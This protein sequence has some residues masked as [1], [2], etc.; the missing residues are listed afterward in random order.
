MSSILIVDDEANIR[1][2][3]KGAL[4]RE[5]YQVEDAPSVAAARLRRP[6]ERAALVPE[7]F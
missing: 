4:A 3:L 2:S 6:C 1:S 5:G 7:Q